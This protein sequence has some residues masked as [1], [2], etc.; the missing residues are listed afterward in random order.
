MIKGIT[1][2]GFEFEVDPRVKQDWRLIKAIADVQSKED[3]RA[4]EGT[5]K[6]INII[7]GE[8]EEEIISH[9]ASLNDGYVPTAAIMAEIK[10]IL[11]A[12][13]NIKK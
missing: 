2:S 11:N 8:K 1:Q 9:I 5:V 10:D 12:I 3:D 6:L 7:L 13:P 4:I